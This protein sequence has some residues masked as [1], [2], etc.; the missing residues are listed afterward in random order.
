MCQ[1]ME[2]TL[3]LHL[4]FFFFSFS[5]LFGCTHGMWKFPGQ[6]SNHTTV[7]I[8]ATAAVNTRSVTCCYHQEVSWNSVLRLLF[9]F[10]SYIFPL[11][12]SSWWWSNQSQYWSVRSSHHDSVVTNQTRIHT[13]GLIPGLAQWVKDPVLPWAVVQVTDVSQIWRC[14]GCGV[15]W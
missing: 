3:E 9:A 1:Y 7:A 13:A 5:F 14:C 4:F 12:S 6:G 2:F 15:G 10:F 11:S 8:C